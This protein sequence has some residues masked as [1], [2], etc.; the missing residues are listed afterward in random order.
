MLRQALADDEVCGRRV[1]RRSYV[2][3]MPWIVHRHRRLWPD[4]ER[5]DPDRF[6]PDPARGHGRY[7]YIPFGVGLH[8][9]VAASL[10]VAEI[11]V[12]MAVLGQRLRFRLAPG[13]RI[14]PAWSTLRP[15][16][17]IMMTVERG[18]AARRHPRER[19]L[20]ADP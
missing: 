17:G 16:D 1:P 18:M 4:P 2:V 9:C 13:Q 5:F 12:A 14:E 7:A 3:V 15:K 10:A 6:L 8:V 19:A 20:L 11:L